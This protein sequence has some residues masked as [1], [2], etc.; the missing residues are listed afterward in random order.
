MNKKHQGINVGHTWYSDS[1]SIN[2]DVV[3]Y[4]EVINEMSNE[5]V[6]DRREKYTILCFS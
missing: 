1:I 5:V 2:I 3:C 4:L 6:L